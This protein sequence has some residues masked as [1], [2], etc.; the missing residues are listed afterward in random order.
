[1]FNIVNIK[2]VKP[3]EST[4]DKYNIKYDDNQKKYI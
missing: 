3:K 2:G 4:L 1:M